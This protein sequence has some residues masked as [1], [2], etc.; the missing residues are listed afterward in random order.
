MTIYKGFTIRKCRFLR[1]I[2]CVFVLGGVWFLGWWTRNDRAGNPSLKRAGRIKGVC[3]SWILKWH[4]VDFKK[5]VYIPVTSNRFIS[6]VYSLYNQSEN[7][8]NIK[9]VPVYYPP[10]RI[11]PWRVS[12][13]PNYPTS[14]DS[15]D[16]GRCCSNRTS[17]AIGCAQCCAV[18]WPTCQT[19]YPRDL[20]GLD[21]Q[22]WEELGNTVVFLP[23][24]SPTAKT[25]PIFYMS[26]HRR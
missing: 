17:S 13:H 15:A 5:I 9:R 20:V 2:I 11:Y 24:L 10:R 7:M 14:L 4:K 23:W 26:I 8:Y 19:V 18:H 6:N 16:P 22:L 3:W 21:R 25:L 1:D 12:C